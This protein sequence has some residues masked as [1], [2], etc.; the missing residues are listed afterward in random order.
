MRHR[1]RLAGL[2]AG[3]CLL[4]SPAAADTLEEALALAYQNNPTLEAARAQLRVTDENVVIQRAA[5]LPSANGSGG[6]TEFITGGGGNG[7]SPDRQA[8]AN[9]SLGVPL[10]QGGAVRNGTLAAE[11]RIDAGRADL[12]GTESSLF[13][14]VVAAYMDVILNEAVVGLSA[15]NVDVL[16]VNVEAT[17]DRFEIG[18]LTRTD[19]A[20][21][22]SRLALASGDLRTA[23][24][25]LISARERY[26][27][28]VGKAPENLQPPRPL[29][30]LP[31]DVQTAVEVALAEN[32]DLIAAQQLAEAADYDIAVAGA[33]RLPRVEL[34]GGPGYTNYLGSLGTVPGSGV[35]ADQDSLSLQAGVRLTLPIF[36]GGR[37]AAQQRQ[38]G[39]RAQ[40]ALEQ[41]VAAERAVISQVRAA[42]ASWRAANAIIASSQ[43]AVDAAALSLEGV[44]AENTV[45]NRTI[46]DILNAQQE[47]LRAQVQLVTARRN[48]YVAGFTLLAA[49][50]R[51]EA[52]DLG[53]VADG[54][55][56]DPRDNYNRVRDIIWDWQ[57]DPAPVVQSTR[58]VDIPAADGDIP[59][60]TSDDMVSG[61]T[62]TTGN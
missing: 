31:A 34:V 16:T 30:D 42:Y 62:G 41:V 40:V 53:V 21:S 27:Q 1:A 6:Y 8:T 14:Q 18:D 47:L 7:L 54:E 33:G 24:S 52:R 22:E 3:A 9:L 5:G 25:N 19:V 4:A 50:G 56:Y 61:T 36:Q 29:G 43:S 35:T 32:P 20:Q 51:A 38:A 28:L 49:M 12:R 10:Y 44:R 60:T 17:R 57:R 26:I 2:L 55:L 46:L 59:G 15:N 37:V 39:A 45:G 13:S 48:A 11:Y 58:T 23:Q